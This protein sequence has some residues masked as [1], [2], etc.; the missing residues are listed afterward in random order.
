VTGNVIT[1][2]IHLKDG[3]FTVDVGTGKITAIEL[4]ADLNPPRFELQSRFEYSTAQKKESLFSS[5]LRCQHLLPLKPFKC[6][7][8]NRMVMPPP[9]TEEARMLLRSVREKSL[10]E[11]S[12]KQ[13]AIFRKY[14]AV[15]NPPPAPPLV[16]PPSDVDFNWVRATI[17]A[18]V[19]SPSDVLS[20]A[21]HAA[22]DDRPCDICSKDAT[23]QCSA[24]L[25]AWYCCREH[26]VHARK[27]HK[28]FCKRVSTTPN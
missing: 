28:A 1:S 27:N 18:P 12:S 3:A 23:S 26:Q 14:D 21:M 15:H 20:N 2:P 5:Y 8:V 4:P 25:G 16:A 17:V 9:L 11:S 10:N 7:D 22:K 24:C 6:F 19:T 13:K